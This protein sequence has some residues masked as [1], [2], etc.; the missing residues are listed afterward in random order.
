MNRTTDA[1]GRNDL[2]RA[3]WQP[4]GVIYLCFCLASLAAG[5]WPGVIAPRLNIPPTTPLPTLQTL[6]AGQVMF[7]LLGYPIV[8]LR[9]K[10]GLGTGDSGLGGGNC[11]LRI[12]DCGLKNSPTTDDRLPTT[13]ILLEL[14]GMFIVT[15]PLYI[16]AAWLSDATGRDVFRTA[17]SVTAYCPLGVLAGWL[18]MRPAWRGWVLLGLLVIVLGLP[19]AWYI[20]VDFLGVSGEWAWNLSPLLQT[21]TTAASRQANYL[22][23]PTWAW[24][25]WAIF[26][27]AG[28]AGLWARRS[29]KTNP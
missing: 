5:L 10:G 14:A 24:L 17:L 8:L 3:L 6:A 15:A 23:H 2:L 18:L 28:G 7:F 22:P 4:A 9:R 26:A 19:G 29:G 20:C 13:G 27:T 21:W 1:P 11:G 12:A 25:F 16:I